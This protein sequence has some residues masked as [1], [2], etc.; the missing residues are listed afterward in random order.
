VRREWWRDAVVYQI[1]PRSFADGSGD[2]IGDFSGMISRVPYLQR[3]G[4]DAV[5]ISP[6]YTSPQCDA[7]YDVADYVGVDPLFGTLA[8]FDEFTRSLHEADIRV[9]VDLVP[10]HSS[11]DHEWFRAALAAGAGSPERAR[12]IFRPGLGENAELPPN[13][14]ESVFGGSA[15]EPVGDGEWYLHL[16]DVGQPDFDWSN[17]DVA[18]MFDD[19]LR[20][21]LDRGVDGFRI[22]VAHG[23]IKA[24]G[25]PDNTHAR[26]LQAAG[27]DRGPMWD[28]DGVHD[29]YRRWR[30]ILQDYPG[31]RIL[32]AEAWVSP[33]DRMARY[34]RPD[35]MH[36]SF[37]FPF[38]LTG[39]S[40]AG[41]RTQIDASLAANRTVG[42]TTTW[43]LSNHDVVRHTT[44][45]GLP[46]GVPWTDGIGANDPQ[47]DARLGLRRACALTLLELALPGSA[48]IYQGEELGLPEHTTL[49]DSARQDPN[50][51]RTGGAQVGRD[52]C[53]IPLP[54][55]AAAPALGF[56]T[57]GESWLPQP[58]A[59]AAL[60]VDQQESDPTS[61]LS[62][63]RRAL[64]VRR[65]HTDPEA[66]VEWN[67]ADENV[68]DGTIGDLRVIVVFAGEPVELSQE[69]W[70]V[71]LASGTHGV[72]DGRVAQD[73]AVWL[74]R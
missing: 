57:T 5:W 64:Q 32:V 3:L 66:R 2:G 33:A 8:D 69:G 46:D 60:A 53:R 51:H 4:I 36:Q 38:L 67:R 63:Y 34:V 71:A 27:G 47:P 21:W 48:Y 22:D 37:N 40:A 56:N 13:N 16:F 35:E 54:W 74:T 28:Q 55:H 30:R 26:D 70:Q 25:L 17:P 1:Y 52:G 65:V 58:D 42:A 20:F 73:A 9:I 41:L 49:D 59:Y 15:W 10:N 43:V 14:W 31:D 50:F 11:V 24:D 19:V 68:L 7:G 23:L 45:L 6:F 29:V 61:T 39:W 18:D 72:V 12:Y 62:L 44:R